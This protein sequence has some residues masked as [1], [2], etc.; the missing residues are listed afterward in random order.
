MPPLPTIEHAGIRVTLLDIPTSLE[1]AQK[2]DRFLKADI[3]PNVPYPHTE[4]KGRKRQHALDALDPVQLQKDQQLEDSLQSAL[5]ALRQHLD[6]YGLVWSLTRFPREAC[7]DGEGPAYGEC[8]QANYIPVILSPLQNYFRSVG[9]IQNV[10]V[11]NDPPLRAEIRIDLLLYVIPPRST[12]LWTSIDRG[13]EILVEVDKKFDSILMDPPWANRS[14]QRSSK[15]RTAELQSSDPFE[16]A[17][18]VIS[19]YLQPNGLVAVWTSNKTAVRVQVLDALG[20]LGFTLQ[21]EWTWLKIAGNGEPVLPLDGVWRKPYERLLLLSRTARAIH[22]QIIVAVPD[23]HSRKPA[24]KHLLEPHLP[25]K[26]EALE[27]FARSLTAGWWSWGDEVLK[28]QDSRE[29]IP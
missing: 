11:V 5:S 14:V 21:A 16:Q 19:K 8:I 22:P 12:F 23:V 15:Y 9:E 25:Y 29:W 17:V 6:Q 4:P 27:M 13:L 7:A 24:L 18:S 20:Y 1:T 10:L 28:F 2:S 26:Y 3:A